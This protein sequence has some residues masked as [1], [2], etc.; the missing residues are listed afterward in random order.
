MGN[1]FNCRIKGVLRLR[2][3]D[4][5]NPVAVGDMVEFEEDGEWG[6]IR[7]ILPRKNHLIRKSKKLSKQSQVI[8]ANLD[9]LFLVVTVVHPRTSTGFID[10]Y[11]ATCEAYSIPATIVFNKMD[12]YEEAALNTY[13]LWKQTYAPLGYDCLLVSAKQKSGFDSLKALL[14][15]GIHLFSGHSGVGKSTL[16]NALNP[17]LSLKEGSISEHHLK[18]QNTTTFAAMHEILPDTWIVDTPGIREFGMF[19]F[20]RQELGHYFPEMRNRMNQCRFDNC[21][22][23]AEP[24]CAV[25]KA[26]EEGQIAAWRFNNYLSMLAGEDNFN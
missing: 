13:Q 15:P 17:A 10:R 21:L 16:L 6:Q 11:L 20:S 23:E 8:A 4:Q 25:K 3:I 2:G 19:D 18:G 26:V 9:R 7:D 12:L 14:S 22:H 1:N 5:T 24:G